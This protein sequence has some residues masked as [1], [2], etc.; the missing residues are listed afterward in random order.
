MDN[1]ITTVN[2][3]TEK[4]LE[5]LN[6]PKHEYLRSFITNTLMNITTVFTEIDP[7]DVSKTVSPYALKIMQD[8]KILEVFKD[9]E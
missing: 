5:V 2:I 6:A 3:D 7:L 9:G 8:L 4:L 1:K